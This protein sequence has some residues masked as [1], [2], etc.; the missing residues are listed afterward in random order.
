MSTYLTVCKA[1]NDAKKRMET[2]RQD[3]IART[4]KR[5]S[6]ITECPVIV[7]DFKHSLFIPGNFD[8]GEY[9]L[10]SD[11]RVIYINRMFI[12]D[13]NAKMIREDT[14]VDFNKYSRDQIDKVLPIIRQI[15]ESRV[16]TE[17]EQIYNEEA[18]RPIF[19]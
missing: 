8:H 9:Q 10:Y 17:I 19:Q 5:L 12:Y 7:T 1:F 4:S 18:N 6:A 16:F 14:L 3:F 11:G 2:A 13:V 15:Y